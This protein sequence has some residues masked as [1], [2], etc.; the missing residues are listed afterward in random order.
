M[1]KR[2]KAV[3]WKRREVF[4]CGEQMI[5]VDEVSVHVVQ[6]GSMKNV[7]ALGSQ[8]MGGSM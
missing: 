3:L 7:L 4:G 5:R 8:E 1:E 6:S 2:V